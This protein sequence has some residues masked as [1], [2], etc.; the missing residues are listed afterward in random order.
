MKDS[1]S[2][3]L[4]SSIQGQGENVILLH[5]LFG[6][7]SN[8]GMITKALVETH[9]V[10]SLDLRNHGQSPHTESMTIEQLS[11]DVKHYIEKQQIKECAVIGHSLG[12]KVAMQLA[13]DHPQLITK[14]IIADI[15]PVDYEDKHS[16]IINA[17]CE[18]NLEQI[19]TR[20]EASEQLTV[21]IPEA[22]VRQFLLMNLTKAK[23]GA[24]QWRMNLEAIKSNY[25][26]LRENINSPI[27]PNNLPA[28][29]IKGEYSD[30][31][32]PEHKDAI[33]QRFPNA[34]FKIIQG[35]NHWL[36]AEKPA[37]FNRLCVNFLN[38]S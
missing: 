16:T 24:Y 33:Q 4:H 22:D 14:I 19:S 6:M 34:N 12:G 5:G 38:N 3:D 30:Y 17:L 36:H 25:R 20:K 23:T 37:V 10:H 28:L 35:T 7:G 9:C 31:I 26:H 2:I 15:A 32:L 11:S 18:L 1:S 27:I 21:A 13:L 8:L 29:F